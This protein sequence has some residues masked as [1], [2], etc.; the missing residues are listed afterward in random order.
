MLK[1]RHCDDPGL[2]ADLVSVT[3][4]FSKNSKA[5][6]APFKLQ[7][8]AVDLLDKAQSVALAVQRESAS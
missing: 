1:E 4:R 3:G 8:R 6:Q 5:L 7:Q 2:L